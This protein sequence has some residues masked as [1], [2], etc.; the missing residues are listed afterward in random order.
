M[1]EN[2]HFVENASKTPRGIVFKSGQ[3][4]HM[5]EIAMYKPNVEILDIDQIFHD[6]R[7]HWQEEI[8]IECVF[9]KSWENPLYVNVLE[10]NP[11]D[12]WNDHI[13]ES[14]TEETDNFLKSLE[15]E[16]RRVL[17]LQQIDEAIDKGDEESFIKYTKELEE[18]GKSL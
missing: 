11:Y 5:K 6:L 18:L 7:M 16:S 8:Y 15:F 17:L 2:I 10:D 14:V 12:S 13:D 1:I 3:P 4:F 9:P